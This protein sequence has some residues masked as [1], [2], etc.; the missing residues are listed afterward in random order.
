MKE[1]LLLVFANKQD[2]AGGKLYPAVAHTI[3]N[4]QRIG[5]CYLE[6]RLTLWLKYSYESKR[7]PRTPEAQ[8][9]KGQNMVRCAKLCNYRGGHI[10]GPG[11]FSEKTEI[12]VDEGIELMVQLRDGSPITSSHSRC[13][14]RSKKH[15]FYPNISARPCSTLQALLISP[16]FSL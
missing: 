10:R 14:G 9:A 2:I 1:A 12:T 16:T 6:K 7:S 11:K 8:S 5:A 3:P 4:A 13:S 15:D